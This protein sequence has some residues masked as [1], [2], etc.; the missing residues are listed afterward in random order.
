MLPN[1][2]DLFNKM[3]SFFSE[4]KAKDDAVSVLFNDLIRGTVI[5][6]LL[7]SL[8]EIQAENLITIK[9]LEDRILELEKTREK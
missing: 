5:I 4:N 6:P 3:N 7:K 8:A 1:S 2:H 9:K